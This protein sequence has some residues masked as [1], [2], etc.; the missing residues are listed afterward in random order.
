MKPL[1]KIEQ[2]AEILSLLGGNVVAVYKTIRLTHNMSAVYEMVQGNKLL[3]SIT[4]C[5]YQCSWQ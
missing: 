4:L 1:R 3:L 2:Q 5:E